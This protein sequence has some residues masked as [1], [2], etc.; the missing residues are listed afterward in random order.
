[1]SAKSGKTNKAPPLDTLRAEYR[2]KDLGA[3]VRGK[4][5]KQHA[6]GTNLVLLQP[7]VARVFSTSAAVNEALLGLMQVAQRTARS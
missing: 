3:G 6:Q 1:M 5:F 2:R 7:E 4:Y